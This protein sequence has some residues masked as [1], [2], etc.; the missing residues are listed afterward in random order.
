MENRGKLVLL[1]DDA[2]TQSLTFELDRLPRKTSQETVGQ[3]SGMMFPAPIS[4]PTLRPSLNQTILRTL[5]TSQQ[6]FFWA[7]FQFPTPAGSI[8]MIMVQGPAP[9]TLSTVT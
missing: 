7:I 3:S 8:L 1:V 5:Q 6:C 9:R 4:L 2:F